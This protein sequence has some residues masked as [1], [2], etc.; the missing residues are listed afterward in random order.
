M[1]IERLATVLS[2]LK[3]EPTKEDI[4]DLVWL[5]AQISGTPPAPVPEVTEEVPGGKSLPQADQPGQDDTSG[6]P[7]A[8]PR[9]RP[10]AAAARSGLQDGSLYLEPAISAVTA[11]LDAAAVRVPAASALG[12]HLELAGALRPFKRKVVS[13]HEL[14]LDEEATAVRVAETGRWLPVLRPALGRWLDLALVVDGSESMAIWQRSA[15]ELRAV[16]ERLGAFSDVR[17]WDLHY[18][19]GAEPGVALSRRGQ[20]SERRGVRELVDPTGRRVIVVVSDCLGPAWQDQVAQQTLAGWAKHGPVAVIQPLPQRLW[21]RSHVKPAAAVLYAPKPGCPNTNL[22]WSTLGFGEQYRPAIGQLLMPVPLLELDPEWL[23]PWGRLVAASSGPVGVD[24]MVIFVSEEIGRKDRVNGRGGERAGTAADNSSGLADVI[25]RRFIASAAPDAVRLAEYL[26]AAP[27]S[28]PVIRL[29][30][31]AVLEQTRQS[32]LAEVLLGGL[33]GRTGSWGNLGPEEVEYDFLP[34]VRDIL[35]GRLHKRAAVNVISLVSEYLASRFGQANDFR[36]LLVGGL[37]AGEFTISTESRPFAKV[38]EHVLRM[39]GGHYRA[40]AD[41]LALALGEEGHLGEGIEN[42][43]KLPAEGAVTWSLAGADSEHDAETESGGYARVD[44]QIPAAPRDPRRPL[45]C[46]YCYAGFSDREILFRC[47]GRVGPGGKT[48]ER[49]IDRVLEKEMGEREFLPPVFKI[50]SRRDS[51]PCPDCQLLS[52][53]QVCPAC[54][55]RLPAA[56]RSTRGR[57]IALAGPSQ[58]GKTAFMTVLIHELRNEV[59]EILNS[60]VRGADRDSERRY[61]N[62]LEGRLYDQ[63]QLPGRTTTRSQLH[64]PPLVFRFTM[65]S[66]RPRRPSRRS[67]SRSRTAPARTWCRPTRSSR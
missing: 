9:S 55:S 67:C 34:G 41:A 21:R 63:Q 36:A 52:R 24:A 30:Q 6:P 45:A 57:F 23:Y 20:K 12:E 37:A 56:F 5:A 48:C 2:A 49:Q 40:A 14:V 43:R 25:V 44:L 10:A 16:F 50:N 26:S 22:T 64:V 8:A 62:E 15:D 18:L 29:V 54:H 59:G 47:E 51:A 46:P 33:L 32:D 31:D 28:L 17:S 42:I 60:R 39:V 11:G 7:G 66:P 19:A 3:L 61:A 27:V 53:T 4:L 35:L 58:S 38:A 13:R 1:Q 65:P